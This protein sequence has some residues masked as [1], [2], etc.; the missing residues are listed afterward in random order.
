MKFQI[1][2]LDASS[3][4][5]FQHYLTSSLNFLNNFI[6]LGMQILGYI[7]NVLPTHSSS[8]NPRL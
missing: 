3:N 2:C 4:I 1:N 5:F 6:L 7:Y 8:S